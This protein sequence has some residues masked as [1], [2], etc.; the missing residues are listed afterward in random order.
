MKEKVA[1]IIVIATL[2]LV[3]SFIIW[4]QFFHIPARD[5]QDAKVVSLTAVGEGS[6][7]YTTEQVYGLN[8]WW[9][10]FDPATIFLEVGDRVLLRLQSADVTHRFY[11]P[12]LNIGPVDVKPGHTEKV[13]FIA[14]NSGS[15]QYFCTSICG[16]CHFY[17]TG[18]VV[19]STPGKPVPAPE[20]V[21]CP[22]CL[23][24]T[25]T[26]LPGNLS[27]P[28][29]IL[30]F[31]LGC[32][33]CHGVEGKGGVKNYNY[34]TKTIPA[35]NLTAEKLFLRTQEAAE[36]FAEALS[37][38]NDLTDPDDFPGIPMIRVVVDRCQALKNIIRKGSI[39]QKLD[40][41]GPEPPHRMPA[42]KYQLTDRDI[43]ELIIY[44]INLYPWEE[45]EE[46]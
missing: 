29:E 15:F 41:S 45:T 14:T 2:I 24:D 44:F 30:F 25:G 19:V 28:G 13:N 35:H 5:Y 36:N 42:W 46:L 1:S 21:N 7:A 4:Y 12:A 18:W 33:T 20:P 8:Y 9:K 10:R 6:G 26:P 11:I 27:E 23:S 37:T 31:T 40:P 3:P 39:P 34:A 32:I 43:D 22:M 16:P 38:H 17:M